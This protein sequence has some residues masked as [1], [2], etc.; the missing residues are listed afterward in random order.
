MKDLILR[1]AK[2]PQLPVILVCF[3]KSRPSIKKKKMEAFCFM[4]FSVFAP[5]SRLININIVRHNAY[6]FCK[7]DD[8]WY[9]KILKIR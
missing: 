2:Y 7:G 3:F 1:V 8:F 6:K 4:Y 9:I 5:E